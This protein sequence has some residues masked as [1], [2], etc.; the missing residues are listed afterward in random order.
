[1]KVLVTGP[2]GFAGTRIMDAFS[3]AIPAPSLREYNETDVQRLLDQI[4]PDLI[5]HTAAISDIQTCERHPDLSWHAN[6]ELPVWLVRSGVKTILFSSDQVYSGSAV[7][8][9]YAEED[10]SPGNVYARH[11]VEME[12]RAL[13]LRPETVILRVTWM[14]DLPVY[15]VP[16]RGNYLMNMLL[17]QQMAFSFSQHR[18]VTY[19]RDVAY[20]T[21]KAA[22]L[23]GG[24]YNFGSENSFT[25]LELSS[26]LKNELSLS[27]Q[28]QDVG[29]RHP[30]WM[31]CKKAQ[32]HGILFPSTLDGLKRC[33]SD[34]SLHP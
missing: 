13:D 14:Y 24:I 2:R 18:A 31:C 27:V 22:G 6:V 25:M 15:G 28:F 10:T 3:D 32:S 8:G 4:Q 12:R 5:I 34:Y 20:W 19:M 11:K 23:S 16:N 1:M 26:W 7:D 33:I 30:L 21:K 29:L 9:P 17:S